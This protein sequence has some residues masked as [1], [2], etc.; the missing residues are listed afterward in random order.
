[1]LS[2][3]ID[4][5]KSAMKEGRKSELTALRNLIGKLKAK[6]IDKG[7][8]LTTDETIKIIKNSAKKLKDSINQYKNGGRLDLVE[9]E[10]FELS[11][12]KKYLP[13]EMDEKQILEKVKESIISVNAQTTKD[14]GKV[15]G[16]VMQKIGNDADGQTVQNIVRKELN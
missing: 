2:K 11:I 16:D 9:K 1:M 12:V 4:D 5:M 6:K 14:M 3:L 10:T 13:K 8:E 15:M 7:E